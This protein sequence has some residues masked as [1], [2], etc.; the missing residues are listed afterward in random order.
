MWG[1][2]HAADVVAETARPEVALWAVRC[3]AIAVAAGAQALLLTFVIGSVY[4]RG[5][6]GDVLNGCAAV[7]FMLALASATALGL[8]AGR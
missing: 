7:V 2:L 5:R 8:A 6:A 1:W 4:G 3:A